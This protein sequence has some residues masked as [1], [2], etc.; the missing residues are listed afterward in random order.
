MLNVQECQRVK[1]VEK[2]CLC[3]VCGVRKIDKGDV[4][5][6]FVWVI[7]W[8]EAGGTLQHQFA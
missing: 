5:K 2:D 6:R 4:V 8:I 1:A 7:K 3:N